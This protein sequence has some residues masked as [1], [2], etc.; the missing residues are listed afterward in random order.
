MAINRKIESTKETLNRQLPVNKFSLLV[1]T[2]YVV[3]IIGVPFLFYGYK[4]FPEGDTWNTFLGVYTS[5]SWG[6]VQVLSWVFLGKL[7]PFLLLLIWFFS[8]KH[9]WYHALLVPI[10]M[11]AFQMF[12]TLREDAQLIDEIELFALAPIV[13]VVAIFLYTIRTKIFD[14]LHGID[15]SELGRVSWKGDL[16]PDKKEDN[17]IICLLYTS[18]SPRDLSTSRMPSSA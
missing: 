1:G 4:A 8:C 6:S 17:I 5:K 7:I 18:P 14:K 13:L 2:L 11:Y 9:W 3:F 10:S 12:S 16:A 15:L